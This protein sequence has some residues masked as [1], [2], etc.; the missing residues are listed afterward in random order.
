MMIK[1]YII[2]DPTNTF[3]IGAGANFQVPPGAVEVEWDAFDYSLCMLVDGM[4]EARPQVS[5]PLVVDNTVRFSDLPEG[6]VSTV[7]DL[8]TRALLATV[9]SVDGVIE[10]QLP[11]PAVY[12][13]E[14][15]APLPWISWSGRVTC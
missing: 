5:P 3:P 10:F 1:N 15:A 2:M 7:T 13:V 6:A 4:W 14:V 9:P 11:D 12:E 8:E